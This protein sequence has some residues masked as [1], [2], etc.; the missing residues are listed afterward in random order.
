MREAT[1]LLEKSRNETRNM[2]ERTAETLGAERADHQMQL[3]ELQDQM[4]EL[5]DTQLYLQQAQNQNMELA[6][7]EQLVQSELQPLLS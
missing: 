7:A 5:T 4:R 3:E 6:N 1:A 2:Y